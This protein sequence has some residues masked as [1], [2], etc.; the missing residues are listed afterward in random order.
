MGAL[1]AGKK[2]KTRTHCVEG[3][4][5]FIRRRPSAVC[6]RDH[7]L[8]QLKTCLWEQC[9]YSC[10]A[11]IYLGRAVTT[12]LSVSFSL[13]IPFLFLAKLP[14]VASRP[15]KRHYCLCDLSFFSYYFLPP[16]LPV[17]Q[18]I[19][20]SLRGPFTPFCLSNL[21]KCVKMQIFPFS[22]FWRLNTF[23]F[24]FRSVVFFFNLSPDTIINFITPSN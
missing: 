20:A 21:H 6:E 13:L 16:P 15:P 23:V 10:H 18:C 9:F 17:P 2:Q 11:P 4:S 3:H 7:L 12:N 22:L 14:W 8:W 1:L 5:C 24:A 19:I